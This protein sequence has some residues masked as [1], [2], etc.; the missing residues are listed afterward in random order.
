MEVRHPDMAHK[1]TTRLQVIGGL[2]QILALTSVVRQEILDTLLASGGLSVREL[3]ELLGRA[4]D[5]LYYHIRKLMAVGLL[6]QV[7]SRSTGRG[8]EA[9]YN[10]PHRNYRL[11]H[12]L[13][14]RAHRE[15]IARVT[16]AILRLTERTYRRAQEDPR[17]VVTGPRRNLSVGRS[18]GWA[19]P[20][21][22]EKINRHVE[23]I[24]AIFHRGERPP[25]SQLVS[26]TNATILLPGEAP[27]AEPGDGSS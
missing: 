1:P 3:G 4:P 7:E 2:K 25:G 20:Q 8:E 21:D 12:D 17:A 5:S 22:M 11:R 27:P 13:G 10:V 16:A 26:F 9:V 24:H 15:A 23:A 19:T 14:K 6:V 18:V